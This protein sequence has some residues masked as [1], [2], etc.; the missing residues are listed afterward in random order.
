MPKRGL[1]YSEKI[2]LNRPATHAEGP[3]FRHDGL[4][5]LG[6]IDAIIL[7]KRCLYLMEETNFKVVQGD[8]FTI[9]VMYKNPNGTA[10]DLTDYTVKMD[11]RDKPGGKILCGSA[12]EENGGVNIDGPNGEIDIEFSSSQTKK[13]T[14]PT[15]AY[16]ILLINN[17]D[18]KKTTLTQGYFKVSAAVVK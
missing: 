2:S 12:T 15:A 14:I 3:S 7:T 10:V 16:Q 6:L 1:H 11:V 8:T 18:G 4:S 9:K 13:F 17:D 5:V